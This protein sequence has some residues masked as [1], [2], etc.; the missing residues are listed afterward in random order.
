MDRQTEIPSPRDP[1]TGVTI[2]NRTSFLIEDI[3]Y[4]QKTAATTNQEEHYAAYKPPPPLHQ[5]QQVKIENEK[6]FASN[7]TL[8]NKRHHHHQEKETTYGYFQPNAMQGG[9]IQG[10]QQ[11]ENGYIQ[12]MG[13]ALGAYLGSPYK[14]ISDPYFLTQGIKH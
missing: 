7:K 10:F 11:S 5:H 1:E 4:R 8:E 9:C 12:V 13:A 6:T 14:S 3:L 2:Q